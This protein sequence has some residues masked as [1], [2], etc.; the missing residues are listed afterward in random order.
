[1]TV[2]GTLFVLPTIHSPILKV[3][4]TSAQFDQEGRPV[5]VESQVSG[6]LSGV[7]RPT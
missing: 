2:F 4:S 7:E 5:R 6:S 3:S 1:M